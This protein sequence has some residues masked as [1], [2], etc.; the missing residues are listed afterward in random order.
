MDSADAVVVGAGVVGLAVARELALRG[1]EV[2]ILEAAERFGTGASSR[3]SEVIH[4]GIYYPRGSLKARLCVAGRERLYEF[5]RE[6][7]IAHRRCGKLIVASTAAQLPELTRIG[8][9]AR[10]NG[11]ELALLERPEALALE[12]RLACAA[13]LHSPLTGI[14][15][16]QG[17]MLALL[18]EAEHHGATLVCASTVTRVVLEEHTVRIGVNGAEAA[19]RARTLV[20]CAGLQAPAV[21]R[22]MKGFPPLHIPVAH[23]AKGNYFTLNTA[24]PFQRLI[25]PLPEAGGLGIHLT[26]DLAG[27]ARFGPDVQWIEA[28]E[29]AVDERR[30]AVFYAAVRRYWPELK[31]GALQPAYAGVRPKISGPGEPPADFRIDDARTHGVLPVVNLF[32]IESP[33]L[34]ASLAIASEVASRIN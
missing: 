6:R 22:L 18:G 34:T 8:A 7:D 10:A 20:N 2:L 24:A 17:L 4:A 25:Y 1:R 32:G 14:V 19:L 27:R 3:N 12:P 30:A 33:G 11:V 21:A 9:A 13:A 16:A 29:Y 5:C 28:C 23:F 31:D 15:D 26:L